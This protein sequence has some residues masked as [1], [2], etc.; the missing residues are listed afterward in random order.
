MA[1]KTKT[2]T[3]SVEDQL[4]ALHQLQ[5]IHTKVDKI[6]IIRGEL[7][8]EIEDLEGL[9]V[10]FNTKLEKFETELED[11]GYI[12]LKQLLSDDEVQNLREKIFQMFDER[13]IGIGPRKGKKFSIN[14]IQKNNTQR[15]LFGKYFKPGFEINRSYHSH[16]SLLVNNRNG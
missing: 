6:R 3:G 4:K 5:V 16:G 11:E 14:K 9:I 2:T 12:L 15:S 8:L 7:P 10:G 13:E 1:K